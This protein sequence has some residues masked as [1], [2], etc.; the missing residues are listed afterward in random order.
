M[1]LIEILDCGLGWCE[2][3]NRDTKRSLL[4]GHFKG[5]TMPLFNQAQEALQNRRF[6]EAEA[7]FRKILVN[8]SRNFDALHMLGI[9]CSENG[10]ISEAE[11]FFL[12]ALSIDSRFPP[13]FHNY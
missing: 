7:L 1:I 8:D 12:A 2:K 4:F 13:L 5:P 11:Q 9:V 6:K 3:I 10:K